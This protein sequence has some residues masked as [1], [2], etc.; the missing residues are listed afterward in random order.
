M[1]STLPPPDLARH[2]AGLRA[3]ASFEPATAEC[4]AASG[5]CDVA[6]SCTGTSAACPTDQYKPV[7]AVC[8]PAAGSDATAGAVHPLG[9]LGARG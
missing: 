7:I 9:S 1:T 8:R 6:E 4:R 3:A 2:V 5:A